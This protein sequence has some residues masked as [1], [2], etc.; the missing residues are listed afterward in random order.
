VIRWLRQD[1]FVCPDRPDSLPAR[2][3]KSA[4]HAAGASGTHAQQA[5]QPKQ[6]KFS[7]SPSDIDRVSGSISW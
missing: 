1:E 6:S 5:R 3:G 2:L 7:G 4:V